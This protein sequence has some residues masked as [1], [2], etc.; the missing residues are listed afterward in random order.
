MIVCSFQVI[1]GVRK[2][3]IQL[4]MSYVCRK[5]S[6]DSKCVQI[7]QLQVNMEE[8]KDVV[9]TCC[10]TAPQFFLLKQVFLTLLQ[11]FCRSPV[12]YLG[13][14][15]QPKSDTTDN[16]IQ[17]SETNSG[18][19]KYL[20]Y[21]EAKRRPLW[22]KLVR[23]ENCFVVILGV[24]FESLHETISQLFKNLMVG[25]FTLVIKLPV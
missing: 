11:H 23:V 15:A 4:D 12:F 20:S 22:K 5:S 1:L 3:I 13:I 2:F 8:I 14:S 24:A 16:L 10:L 9:N 17:V 7:Y 6:E 18:L 21:S 25:L 19:P